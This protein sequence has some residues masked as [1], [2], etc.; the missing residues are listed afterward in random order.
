MA[1]EEAEKVKQLHEDE[2]ALQRKLT[3]ADVEAEIDAALDNI[4]MNSRKTKSAKPEDDEPQADENTGG[5]S[6][7]ID[8][9]ADT[10]EANS[11]HKTIDHAGDALES[12]KTA[13]VAK[14]SSQILAVEADVIIAKS[15]DELKAERGAT[16][17]NGTAID[18]EPTVQ[19]NVE[20]VNAVL[21]V[22]GSTANVAATSLKGSIANVADAG[23]VT[24]S[25]VDVTEVFVKGSTAN[26]AAPATRSVNGSI[27]N[28]AV[29][30]SLKGST[31]NVTGSDP[32]HHEPS[33]LSHEYG[34]NN[35]EENQHDQPAV[36]NEDAN[37]TTLASK[38]GSTAN[39][40]VASSVKASTANFATAASVKG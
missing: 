27:N 5:V 19:A 26:I 29:A 15:I 35:S 33:P 12:S 16:P 6:E 40:A 34:A 4:I 30:A 31:M 22:K 21:S 17:S 14:L 36:A 10:E 18:Q 25:K 32:S 1:Q 3:A 37:V 11:D 24:G 23:S 7:N 9:K 38:K 8:L 13:S 39:V 20:G 2:E 28:V